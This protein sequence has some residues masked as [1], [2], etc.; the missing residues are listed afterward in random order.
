MAL[1][2]CM[3]T[4]SSIY[5]YP[6]LKQPTQINC[7]PLKKLLFNSCLT[8]IL[9]LLKLFI[10]F[11]NT[12]D[13]HNYHAVLTENVVY[14]PQNAVNMVYRSQTAIFILTEDTNNLHIHTVMVSM[15]R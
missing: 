1:L 12:L 10:F 9:R 8:L 11:I 6:S 3:H 7:H 13:V 4:H 15:L 14:L 5:K 2:Y